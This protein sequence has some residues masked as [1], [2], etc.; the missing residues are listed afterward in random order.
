[1][2]R[3]PGKLSLEEEQTIRDYAPTVSLDHI[4]KKI[5]RNVST[6]KK[7]CDKNNIT[8]V[9][10]SSEIQED[11][12]LRSRLHEK[13][14]WHE[15]KKQLTDVELEYFTVT[16]IRI[17]KQFRE[18]II[19]SEELQVKQW[20]TLEIMANKVMQDRKLAHAQV[21]RVDE[22]LNREY[23]LS[24]EH[25]DTDLIV[26]LE[27]ELS[28]LRGSSSSYTQEHIKILDK[29]EKYQRELKAARAD[30]VR[31]IEDSKSSFAGFIK[32]LEDETRRQLLGEE[33]E[34]NKL[35]KN[36]AKDRLSKFHTYE[37]GSID[38]PLLTPE[39]VKD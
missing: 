24:E 25:R 6:V 4:A 1:M 11:M 2:A 30:R 33:I 16:W 27:Q 29:I 21:V 22:M 31:K 20:I 18:D 3:K 32:A 26:R 34:L 23:S 12:I 15:I 10:M 8:Y 39:N 19:Y 14:Y 5:N 13:P 38:Q 7:Y 9:G 35:A 17:M 37:D 28:M 36:A